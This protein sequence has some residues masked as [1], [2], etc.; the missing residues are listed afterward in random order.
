[1][2]N[3]LRGVVLH[4]TGRRAKTLSQFI[5]GKTGTTN[6]YVDAWFMGFSSSLVTGV[7]TGFDDNKTMGWAETGS[8]SALPIWKGFMEVGLKKYGENDFKVPGGIIHVVINKETGK[9]S[10]TGLEGGFT[11]SFVEGYEP[12][13]EAAEMRNTEEEE[14]GILNE[15][16]YY[17]I[18]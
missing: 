11:E 4:G 8:K 15:D 3:L 12:G 14:G 10:K 18:Q 5:G 1:M 17:N 6:N 13:S 9:P 7:W 2:S 16:D